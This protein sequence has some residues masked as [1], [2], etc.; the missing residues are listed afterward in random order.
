M[1]I[2]GFFSLGILLKLAE[3]EYLEH[4][5]PVILFSLRVYEKNLPLWIGTLQLLNS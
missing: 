3:S 4:V 2:A 1:V 5:S